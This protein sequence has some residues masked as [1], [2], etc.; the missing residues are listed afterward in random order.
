[1]PVYK[2]YLLTLLFC[3][4][5][6]SVPN[7]FDLSPKENANYVDINPLIPKENIITRTNPKKY[8]GELIKKVTDAE[9][10][11]TQADDFILLASGIIESA[12]AYDPRLIPVTTEEPNTLKYSFKARYEVSKKNENRTITTAITLG[13]KK[14]ENIDKI[15]IES[16]NTIFELKL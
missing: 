8:K 16:K 2:Q 12:V 5:C 7:I 6:A 4:G 14:L 3:T 15:L 9:L 13:I 11:I 1:M 10:T